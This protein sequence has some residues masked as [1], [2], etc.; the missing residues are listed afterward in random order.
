MT[1]IEQLKN[2]AKRIVEF[3]RECG[4]R[5]SYS[6]ALELAS[7]RAGYKDWRTAK[8]MLEK[9]ASADRAVLHS[10][11][12][13]DWTVAEGCAESDAQREARY[14][15]LLERVS[16]HQYSFQVVPAGKASGEGSPALDGFIEISHGVPALHLTNDPF[17]DC[18]VSVFATQDG[19]LVR[20][21]S[22]QASTY[23][24]DGTALAELAKL[25][26]DDRNPA[27]FFER[28]NYD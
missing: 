11:V 25:T 24:N 17:A 23:V 16:P 22:C 8:T 21:D 15:L 10:A 7:Q 27:M 13:H 9:L 19:L 14:D 1:T 2:D 3:A 28:Q 26:C 12:M 4:G 6:K 5:P 20:G 18:L